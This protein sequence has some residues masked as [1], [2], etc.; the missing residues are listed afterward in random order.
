ML[1]NPLLEY[2]NSKRSRSKMIEHFVTA[3]LD[4]YRIKLLKE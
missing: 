3:P 1:D 2:S 4:N